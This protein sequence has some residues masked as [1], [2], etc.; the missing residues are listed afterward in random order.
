MDTWTITASI[1][2]TGEQAES[3]VFTVKANDKNTA[4][5][6]GCSKLY[7]MFEGTDTV[8]NQIFSI[9]KVV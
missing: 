6:I 9:T 2:R 1:H 8:I 5:I 4:F 7:A 3:F